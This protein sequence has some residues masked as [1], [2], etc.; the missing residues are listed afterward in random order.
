MRL[1]NE[2]LK[3]IRIDGHARTE[4]SGDDG[5]CAAVSLLARASAAALRQIPSVEVD[6][7]APAPGAYEFKVSY[8]QGAS[9]ERV[10]GVTDLLLTGLRGVESDRPD[11][12]RLRIQDPM[13][14]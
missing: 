4:K 11:L 8:S 7:T 14:R 10:R 5:I 3:S 1:E 13:R 2:R 9:L 6:G 12:C